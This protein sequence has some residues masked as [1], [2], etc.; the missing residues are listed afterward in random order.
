MFGDEKTIS[1]VSALIEKQNT[2]ST[3]QDLYAALPLDWQL[4][5]LSEK[6][7]QP[8]EAEYHCSTEMG[9][10]TMNQQSPVFNTPVHVLL[11]ILSHLDAKS[12]CNLS[13]TCW[14]FHSLCEDHLLWKQLLSNDK[15]KWKE[16]GHTTNPTSAFHADMTFKSIYLRCS[17][18]MRRKEKFNFLQIPRLIKSYFPVQS[19][20]VAM[21]GPGLDSDTSVIVRKMLN[22][23]EN[24]VFCNKGPFPAMFPG[25]VGTG[26]TISVSDGAASHDM[27]M[28]TLYSG[29]KKSREISPLENRSQRSRLLR[30]VAEDGEYEPTP[31]IKQLCGNVNAFICVVESSQELQSV[32]GC[33]EELHCL[34]DLKWTPHTSP[35]LVLSCIPNH[36]TT[37]IPCVTI[38]E[39][40]KLNQ[41]VRQWKVVDGVVSDLQGISSGVR[42][43]IDTANGRA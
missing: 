22:T 29:T 25:S 15:L 41:L 42:W 24:E 38:A 13:Q 32:S 36:D 43:L 19:P 30:R 31:T 23:H 12:L 9:D 35:L 1:E 3:F 28:I 5:R 10:R 39:Q 18:D 40:L 16:V 17:P 8:H 2:S 27:R 11:T 20:K 33:M 7:T 6:V 14:L 4:F 26:F 21:F 37:R 34:M